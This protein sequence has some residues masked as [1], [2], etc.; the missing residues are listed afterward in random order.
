VNISVF[1]VR[2]RL[3]KSLWTAARPDRRDV[4]CAMRRSSC[5]VWYLFH[6]GQSK[7]MLERRRLVVVGGEKSGVVPRAP[8]SRLAELLGKDVPGLKRGAPRT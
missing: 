1:D 5:L 7:T 2:G 4:G 6:C 8:H 3:V